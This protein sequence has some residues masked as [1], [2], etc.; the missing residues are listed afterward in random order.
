MQNELPTIKSKSKILVVGSQFTSADYMYDRIF[1]GMPGS[2]L[3]KAFRS[4]GLVRGMYTLASVCDIP[5]GATILDIPQDSL[6][7][8]VGLKK[9]KETVWAS[10]PNIVVILGGHTLKLLTGINHSLDVYRGSLFICDKL[11]SPLYGRKCIAT[12]HPE[13]L[14]RV[15]DNAPLFNFDIK[16]SH[17]ESFSKALDLP[18]RILV[19]SVTKDK[20]IELLGSIPSGSMI[21]I[22]IEGGIEQG[23]SCIGFA[24]SP[25]YAF[26]V[27][28]KDF[29]PEDKRE[30]LIACRRVLEDSS[31][32]KIMQNGSYDFIS[33]AWCFG[34]N[35]KG[36][37]HD[38]MLS[39]W[40]IYPEL[41]KG[42]GVQASIWTREP[43]YKF[44]RK[45]DDDQV[46]YTYCLKDCCV[47]YAIHLAHMKAM[48]QG[49][50]KH[51]L[52]NMSLIHSTLYMSLKGIKYDVDEAKIMA[53]EV[54]AEMNQVQANID[55]LLGMPVN[56]NSPKQ[57]VEALYKTLGLPP[58]YAK[59]AGRKTSKLTA[60]ADAL[61]KLLVKTGHPFL[62]SVMH[63]KLLESKRKQLNLTTDKDGRMR[64]SYNLV[65]AET[66]RLSC[67]GS[68][69]G[70]GTN[71][72]TIMSPLRK[73]YRADDDMWFFQLDLSGADG[74]TIAAQCAK[75]GDRMMLDDYLAG[76]KPA[77]IIAVMKEYPES[78]KLSRPDLIEFIE[79]HPVR[80]TLYEVCK[81]VQ[82]GTNYIM[83]P[84]GM[85]E[86][87][88]EKSYKRSQGKELIISTSAECKS[89][90]ALYFARYLGVRELHKDMARR[91]AAEPKLS[92]ASGHV[93][94]F[95][96]KN[97]YDT[98]TLGKAMAHAP[99]ANTTYVT[100]VAMKNLWTDLENRR[101]DGSLV[102]EPLH[103]VHD[104]L[105]GQFPKSVTE[106][107]IKKIPRYFD[108][109]INIEGI[110][111][112]IPFE[113]GY[114]PS[115]G[116]L[117]E[118]VIE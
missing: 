36:F 33:L 52:F 13:S 34:I 89:L 27:P 76:L 6:E 92:C 104:A 41:P 24:T 71:L 83:Q 42:L 88:L 105:C 54:E 64:C 73:L 46:Y 47:T 115:W 97:Q 102:I 17:E 107:A 11:D 44:E 40:E 2:L 43:Y 22:D 28:L 90:Q 79:T 35:V 72:Q 98:A 48:D 96:G 12:Y 65:G 69:T 111:L 4:C 101:D 1:M 66:G 23:V 84:N 82:H 25:T 20:A 103:S 109:P 93:R 80:K 49:Q 81:V 78:A 95:F 14:L 19:T 110:E 77:K 63:W 53:K 118:G 50:M 112:V 16:R 60:D 113:G 100:N 39:G 91:I 56:I 59:V 31:I 70:S 67:S 30:V 116:E 74:W 108:I 9:L 26:I 3:D 10:D 18:N 8:E 15:W 55:I 29:E 61:L 21:C 68:L 114:G 106:W 75:L 117:K 37:R 94:T 86:N 62:K 57:M 85:A 5:K 38:T 99:Q 7:M 58:Q 32:V 45:V 51:Y 87:L